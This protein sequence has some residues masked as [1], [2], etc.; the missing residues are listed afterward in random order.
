[1]KLV[2]DVSNNNPIDEATFRRSGAD[3]LIAK[4]TECYVD[5]AG[6]TVNYADPTLEQHR[7][8]AKACGVPFGSYLFLHPAAA[9]NE[10]AFYLE[11]AKPRPGDIPP[12]IDCEVTDGKPV[13]Q[14]AERAEACAAALAHEGYTGPLLYGPSSFLEQ[15]YAAAPALAHLL[16]W[17][18]E[19]PGRFTSWAPSLAPLRYRL[20][21]GAS[22]VLW[23]WT[24]VYAIGGRRFDASRLLGPLPRI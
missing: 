24:D 21:H 17:E 7:A 9:A 6:Q 12:I 10:A 22:V 4:A 8:V 5:A 13:P 14:V 2:L 15:L 19:Y 20:G 16:V 23:Q 11:Y 18:A 3:A 1:M